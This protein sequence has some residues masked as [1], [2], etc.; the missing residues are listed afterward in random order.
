M[1][2]LRFVELLN[3][4]IM[5]IFTALYFYQGIYVIVGLIRRRW[6][7]RHQ[8]SRLR[9][10]AAIV[11]ARN[12]ENVIGEL[13]ESLQKQNYPRELL[14]LYVVADNCTDGT[15]DA[16]RGA[17][18]FVYERFDTIHKGKGYA[19]DY[20]FQKLKEDGKRDY[21]GYFVFDADN[22]VDPNFVWEMNRTFDQG[23]DALTCYRNSKNFGSNWISAGYSIWFLREARFLNFPRMLLGTNCHVSGT[24]FLLSAKVIEENGGWPFHLLTEDIQFS[25]DSAIQG[26]RIGY[27][28]KAE[29]YDEQPTTFH[30]SWEQRLRW[31]KGFYQVDREY[32]LPLLKGCFRKGRLGSSCYD[33]FATVAPGMLL[34]VAMLL[35]NTVLLAIC[36]TQPSYVS[37]YVMRGLS[38]YIVSSLLSFYLIFFLYGLI[39]VISEWKHIS[40]TP[41][42]K[43]G[44]VFTFPLFMFTYIPIAIAA[45]VKKVEWKPI[46]HTATKGKNE[47]ATRSR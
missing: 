1:K 3:F 32:T 38:G 39:T 10:F 26:R 9:R 4:S 47:L 44:Y 23:Y 22:L 14:D 7:D 29:I 37:R 21:E 19:M 18:A 30:Q 24:G 8:P 28:D 25:V 2:M 17:G 34:T 33:M 40:S 41:I 15:A 11:S 46:Y 27:C 31:S 16:A 42:R 20:L 5:I 35:I 36:I 13:L 43:I 45:L 12:E 6:K